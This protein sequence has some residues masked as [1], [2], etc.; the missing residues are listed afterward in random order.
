MGLVNTSSDTFLCIATLQQ[1]LICIFR[2]IWPTFYVMTGMRWV[3]STHVEVHI[4]SLLALKGFGQKMM[5]VFSV[6]AVIE[7]NW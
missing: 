5:D 7:W 4:V 3:W 2:G 1:M 6:L